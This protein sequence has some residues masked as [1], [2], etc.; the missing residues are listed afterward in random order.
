MA[1]IEMLMKSPEK[2]RGAFSFPQIRVGKKNLKILK[3]KK[4]EKKRK[5]IKFLNTSKIPQN[6]P[7]SNQFSANSSKIQKKKFTSQKKKKSKKNRQNCH[8]RP[9]ASRNT[10]FSRKKRR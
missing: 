8:P 3:K 9:A 4:N 10:P 2:Q 7:S 6:P 5:K 1:R